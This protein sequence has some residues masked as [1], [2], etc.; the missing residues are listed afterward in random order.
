RYRCNVRQTRGETICKG[1]VT[2]AERVDF[3]VGEAWV[4]HVTSLEPGDPVLMTI[5]RRWLAFSDPETQEKKESA[6]SALE[7]A[8][9][10]VRKL[11]DDFYVYGKLSEE[12]YEEL[13]RG[14]RATIETMSA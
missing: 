10:R 13:C 11:E 2:L 7:A 12:R 3:A 1:T 5:G 9:K 4:R 8:E 14:Q 6:R